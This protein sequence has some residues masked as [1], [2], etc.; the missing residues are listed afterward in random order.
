MLLCYYI[1][2]IYYYIFHHLRFWNQFNH[3]ELFLLQMHFK[4]L[5]NQEDFTKFQ[6][7]NFLKRAR[8]IYHHL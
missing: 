3:S 7:Q 6:E 8:P 1:I 5:V 4:D 2:F